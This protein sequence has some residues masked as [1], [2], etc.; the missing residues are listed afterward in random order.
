MSG[1]KEMKWALVF[2]FTFM[3]LQYCGPLSVGSV[4]DS[5]YGELA[6]GFGYC[7]CVAFKMQGPGHVLDRLF[8]YW[9]DSY[10]FSYYFENEH[11]TSVTEAANSIIIIN[12]SN[13]QKMFF[14]Y[15]LF[16]FNAFLCVRF[17]RGVCKIAKSDY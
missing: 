7:V 11:K 8:K 13:Q 14:F 6:R 2:N 16:M 1:S 3:S 4:I 10:Y 9:L 17:V 5:A 15:F 12:L